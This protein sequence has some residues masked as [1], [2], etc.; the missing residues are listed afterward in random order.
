M[1]DARLILNHPVNFMWAFVS[2]YSVSLFRNKIWTDLHR[3]S[4]ISI[5]GF[6]DNVIIVRN[7]YFCFIIAEDSH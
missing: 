6:I 3:E 4:F 2:L 7:M 5:G 1:D